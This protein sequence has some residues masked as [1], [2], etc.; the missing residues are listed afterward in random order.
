MCITST[1]WRPRKSQWNMILGSLRTLLQSTLHHHTL[2]SLLHHNLDPFHLDHQPPLKMSQ[3]R[4]ASLYFSMTMLENQKL[5]SRRSFSMWHLLWNQLQ[6]AGSCHRPQCSQWWNLG[7]HGLK[8]SAAR[9]LKTNSEGPRIVGSG[10]MNFILSFWLPMG[11]SFQSTRL[12][13][14]MPLILGS[15]RLDLAPNT[16][17]RRQPVLNARI[18]IFSYA[19]RLPLPDCY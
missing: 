8:S 18:H 6:L 11:H 1:G 12:I 10:H 19:D 13:S 3:T 4:T 17:A 2:K 16:Y 5:K 14:L 9:G 7:S 15:A